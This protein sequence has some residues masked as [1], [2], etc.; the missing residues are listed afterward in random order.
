MAKKNLTLQVDEEVIRRAK[1]IAAQRDT[2]LSGLVSQLVAAADDERSA[3]SRRA[4]QA[5]RKQMRVLRERNAGRVAPAPR[6]WTREDI[7]EERLGRFS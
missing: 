5:W 7:Y 1:V 6:D 2:S 4:H 3:A